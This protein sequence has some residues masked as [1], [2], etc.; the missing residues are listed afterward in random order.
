M[1]RAV[2]W[3]HRQAIRAVAHDEGLLADWTWIDGETRLATILVD[4][5]GHDATVINENG[6][7]LSAH[8]WRRLT[9]AI[10]VN[11]ND[12]SAITI[13]GSVPGGPAPTDYANLLAQC[14]A[15][16][17][18]HK[19]CGPTPVATGYALLLLPAANTKFEFRG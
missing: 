10:L 17:A 6:P 15:G 9:D 1:C 5:S 11:L 16:N 8:E 14:A 13:S 18:R 12:A 3:A 2:G 7:T 19:R 4:G